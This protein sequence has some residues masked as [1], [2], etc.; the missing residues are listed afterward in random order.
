MELTLLCSKRYLWHQYVR[1]IHLDDHDGTAPRTSFNKRSDLFVADSKGLSNGSPMTS[2]DLRC[3]LMTSLILG[4]AF[5]VLCSSFP[6]PIL[7]RQIQVPI[8][9]YINWLKS[10][11]VWTPSLQP[12][13][14]PRAV[15]DSTILIIAFCFLQLFF[16]RSRIQLALF[17]V[18]LVLHS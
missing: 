16:S 2:H 12:L 14:S 15:R 11:W 13:G 10:F 9:N 5:Y 7:Q 1:Y 18:L 8:H 17:P 4:P 3:M 6:S